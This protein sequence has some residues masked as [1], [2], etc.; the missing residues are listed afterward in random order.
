SYVYLD[1]SDS[2][3]CTRSVT[4]SSVTSISIRSKSSLCRCATSSVDEHSYSP[5]TKTNCS[6]SSSAKKPSKI[7][8]LRNANRCS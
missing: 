5:K 8:V 4:T 1:R 2:R 7:L 3:S 6:R